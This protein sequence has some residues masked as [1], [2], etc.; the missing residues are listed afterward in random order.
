MTTKFGEEDT[1]SY[2]EN[3]LKNKSPFDDFLVLSCL[4]KF[5]EREGLSHAMNVFNKNKE[6]LIYFFRVIV[7]KSEK[8]KFTYNIESL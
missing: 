4:N 7:K 1:L 5:L 3:I 6:N 2:V 8:N